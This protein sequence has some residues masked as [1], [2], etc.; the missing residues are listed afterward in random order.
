MSDL[1]DRIKHFEKHCI[2]TNN[3]EGAEVLHYSAKRIENLEKWLIELIDLDV[4]DFSYLDIETTMD[5]YNLTP[6]TVNKEK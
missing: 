3:P 2:E 4:E 5:A 1:I 6:L